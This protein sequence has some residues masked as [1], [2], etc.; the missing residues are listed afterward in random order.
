MADDVSELKE[1]KRELA[2]LQSRLRS[3]KDKERNTRNERIALRL[4]LRKFRNDLKDE[5]NRY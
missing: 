4:Q 2:L 5:R 3:T 1:Q